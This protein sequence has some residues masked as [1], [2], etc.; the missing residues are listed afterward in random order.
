MNDK[1]I[2]IGDDFRQ[3]PKKY[4]GTPDREVDAELKAQSARLYSLEPLTPSPTPVSIS[5]YED[6]AGAS[7]GAGGRSTGCWRSTA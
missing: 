5:L 6:R 1:I 2:S 4:W 7:I 3:W